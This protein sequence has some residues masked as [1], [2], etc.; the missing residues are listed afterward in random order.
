MAEG[1]ASMELGEKSQHNL[2]ALVIKEEK[3]L[4]INLDNF[5]SFNSINNDVE[6]L[7][8]ELEDPEALRE[9]FKVF[10]LKNYPNLLGTILKISKLN[11]E[12]NF[13]EEFLLKQNFFIQIY[14]KSLKRSKFLIKDLNIDKFKVIQQNNNEENLKSLLKSS[15]KSNDE[16]LVKILLLIPF[17][18]TQN[19]V[20]EAVFN[21]KFKCFPSSC[22]GFK[23]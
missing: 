17:K 2:E 6:V 20:H 13:N 22:K 18:I 5:K 11:N 8:F 9:I 1:S 14:D 15:I 7:C 19:L 12:D 10:N 23:F 16:I 21:S 3:I 4:R